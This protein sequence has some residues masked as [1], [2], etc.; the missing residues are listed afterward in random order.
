MMSPD[1]KIAASRVYIMLEENGCKEAYAKAF[2]LILM[3]KIVDLLKVLCDNSDK[4]MKI[5]EETNG[6]EEKETR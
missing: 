2:E 6:L 1:E 3:D 4:I 5:L